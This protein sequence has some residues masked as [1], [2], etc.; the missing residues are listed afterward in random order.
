MEKKCTVCEKS[1]EGKED[2]TRCPSCRR[3]H[4]TNNYY[5]FGI[6]V[7]IIGVVAGIILG[8]SSSENADPTL[9][10]VYCIVGSIVFSVFIFAIHSICHRL[11]AIADSLESKK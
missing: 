3:K 11:D 1:F 2:T 4:G 5:A 9:T 7:I 10:M 6:L 8:S